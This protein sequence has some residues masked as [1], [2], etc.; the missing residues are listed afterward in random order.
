MA[1]G[2]K[3]YLVEARSASNSDLLTAVDRATT[4]VAAAG[5]GVVSMSWGG[6]EFSS[7]AS[8]D[9]HF[10]NSK[11]TYIASACDLPGVIWPSISQYV[12]AA[13]DIGKPQSF[14]GRFRS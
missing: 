10:Q 13:G 6:S 3:I 1:P 2:A 8:Y 5:G 9:S 12:V 7:E 4:L 11:V 14:H